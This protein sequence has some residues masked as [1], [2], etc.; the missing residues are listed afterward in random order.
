MSAWPDDAEVRRAIEALD[1]RAFECFAVDLYAAA[2]FRQGLTQVNPT[3]PGVKDGGI[4]ATFHPHTGPMRKI[5]A[6]IGGADVVRARLAAK[7]AS[8]ETA[9][10]GYPCEEV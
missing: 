4:D 10:E 1:D 9:M 7:W 8:S 3:P 5:D 6:T 2:R